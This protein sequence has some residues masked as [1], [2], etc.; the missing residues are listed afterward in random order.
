MN[1]TKQY[2]IIMYANEQAK[3]PILSCA[4]L[5]TQVIYVCL[6]YNYLWNVCTQHLIAWAGPLTMATQGGR[7]YD[8]LFK[9]LLIGDHEVGKSKILFHYTNDV[10]DSVWISTVGKKIRLFVSQEHM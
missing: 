7:S 9:I 5:F 3:L 8:F 6:L 4:S 10:F 1:T 2:Y